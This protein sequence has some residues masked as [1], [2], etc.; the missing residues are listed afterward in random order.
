VGRRA[1]ALIYVTLCLYHVLLCFLHSTFPGPSEVEDEETK[2]PPE[3]LGSSCYAWRCNPVFPQAYLFRVCG[4][5]L[6]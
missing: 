2:A 1:L 3:C 6:L 5:T 4:T